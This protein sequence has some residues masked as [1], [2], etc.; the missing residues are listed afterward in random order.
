VYQVAVTA[1]DPVGNQR[2]FRDALAIVDTTAP[3]VTVNRLTTTDTSPALSGTVNDS[4]ADIVV[5]VNGVDYDAVNR[6]DGTWSLAAGAIAALP[7][8]LYNVIATAT[9]AVGH[10]ASD[11]STNELGIAATQS[12]TLG[13]GIT[14]VTY[15]DP[16][17]TTVSIV[18]GKGNASVSFTGVNLTV[19]QTTKTTRTVTATGGVRQ[20]NL[21]IVQ[22]TASLTFSTSAQGDGLTSINRITGAGVLGALNATGANLAGGIDMTGVIKSIK[23]HNILSDIVMAG[24]WIRS[25]GVTIAASIIKNSTIQTESIFSLRASTLTGSSI[26]TGVI[27]TLA[28]SV[29]ADSD[30]HATTIKS[31]TASLSYQNTNVTATTITSALLCNVDVDNGGVAFGLTAS[32]I[33]GLRLRQDRILLTWNR[34]FTNRIEDFFVTLA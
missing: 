23:L 29:L 25:A 8:G 12:V 13:M 28:V 15:V 26:Q 33:K 1:T 19:A 7:Q 4:G 6:G 14:K 18:A 11:S 3:V 5:R 16:D 31:L 21:N 24:T 2:V 30:I 9:D 34:T 22:D 32:T 20:L 17:G 27:S 10:V